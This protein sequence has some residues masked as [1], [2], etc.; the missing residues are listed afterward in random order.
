MLKIQQGTTYNA[1]EEVEIGMGGAEKTRHCALS[2]HQLYLL[3]RALRVLGGEQGLSFTATEAVHLKS[4][5]DMFWDV[6]VDNTP[7][8]ST[9]THSLCL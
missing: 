5:Q 6:A 1:D 8:A 7:T 3:Q 9:A 2:T 4:L